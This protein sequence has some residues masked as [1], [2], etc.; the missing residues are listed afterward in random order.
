MWKAAVLLLVAVVASAEADT[1][2]VK[3]VGAKVAE[4]P[5][6]EKAFFGAYRTVTRT[7]VTLTT[8]TVF[9]TCL[10]KSD[11]TKLCNGRRR[12]GLANSPSVVPAEEKHLDSSIDEVSVQ[13]PDLGGQQKLLG[14]VYTIWTTATTSTTVTVRYTN[15]ATTISLDY[16]CTAGS[17]EFPTIFCG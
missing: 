1:K 4:E 12:R 11:T 16:L 10:T 17:I 6:L 3:E 15:T 13:E 8:S 5:A 2:E 9:A 14:G 7:G